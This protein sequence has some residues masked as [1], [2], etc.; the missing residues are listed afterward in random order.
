MADFRYV[1]LIGAARSGTKFLRDTLA[2]SDDVAEVPYDINYVWRH[3][4][5]HR[6]HDELSPS[7]L[8]NKTA[9]HIRK[10]VTRLALKDTASPAKIILEKT[11]SN[12]LRM[13]TIRRVFPEAEFIH[14]ERDGLDVVESSFR[15]WTMPSN[16]GYLI[17][18]LRYFPIREWRYGLWFARNALAPNDEPPIWGPRYK[19]IAGDLRTRGTAQ[20]CALQWKASVTSARRA[21]RKEDTITIRYGDLPT[22]IELLTDRLRLS[23]AESVLNAFRLSFSEVR[24]WPGAIPERDRESC[25]LIVASAD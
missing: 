3:G 22:E 24:S 16:R 4:N 14:L 13:E 19:G 12:T 11:V 23:D 9:R 1:F 17:Q 7:D 5:E 8:D 18:K 10:S 21:S 20:T 2:A 25:S 15:Q 6:T